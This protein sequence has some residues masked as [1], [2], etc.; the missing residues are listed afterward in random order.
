MGTAYAPGLTVSSDHV[1]IKR[2]QLPV[3]GDVLVRLGEIVQHDTVVARAELP[4][5]VE[6]LRVAE[7][8]Q[9][10]PDELGGKIRVEVGDPVERNQLLAESS[11]IFGLFRS[12]VRSP[13]DGTVEF[14]TE[15]TGHLGIRRPPTHLQVKAYVTGQVV[16]VEE[17]QGVSIRT[18]GAFVQGIFGV[19]GERHG[20]LKIVAKSPN[21]PV[22]AEDID[23]SCGGQ[24]LVGGSQIGYAALKK[25]AEVGAAGMVV[26]A[27]SDGDLSQF[28]G[29]DIG[30]AITGDE[31][32][33]LTLV[34]TEG[35]GSIRM[36]ERTFELLK[37]LEGKFASVNGATQIRAGALRPEVVV[38]HADPARQ[39][40]ESEESAVEPQGMTLDI[41]TS[42]RAVRQPY[43]GVIGTVSDL[44]MEPVR[45]ASGAVVRVLK[46]ELPDGTKVVLPRS[47][48]EIIEAT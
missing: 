47:N 20:E 39:V 44:P 25:A 6:T 11:G 17:S 1:T 40:A 22:R 9:L 34:L 23:G 46:M 13:V 15:A 19:G 45:V 2:R 26:G 27:I 37:D 31:D 4:G 24:I 36:A 42:I 5:D 10:D 16:D 32:L 18:R 12:E 33:P 3:S 28:L 43:F 41:G 48:V 35:F 7:R 29:Y 38:P 21:S 30:V 8:M 14:F